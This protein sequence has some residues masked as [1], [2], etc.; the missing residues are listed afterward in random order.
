MSRTYH[1]NDSWGR[2][3]RGLRSHARRPRIFWAGSRRVGEAPGWHV[4]LHD[5]RPARRA[6]HML[7]LAVLVGLDPDAIIW[8]QSPNRAPHTYY[9]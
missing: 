7:E 3:S 8:C 9:W 4:R 1:H 5:I 2:R 6:D